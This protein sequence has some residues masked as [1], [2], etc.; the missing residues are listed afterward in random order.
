[1]SKSLIVILA[2]SL[3]TSFAAPASAFD[4]QP[5]PPKGKQTQST[6]L[7]GSGKTHIEDGRTLSDYNIQKE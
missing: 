7:A 4:P 1:M 3:G 6:K 5:E 2:L